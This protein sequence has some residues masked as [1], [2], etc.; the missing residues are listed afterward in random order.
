M[1]LGLPLVALLVL[2]IALFL[3][4]NRTPTAPPYAPPAPES[5]I[6][7]PALPAHFSGAAHAPVDEPPSPKSNV[8]RAYVKDDSFPK[9]TLEQVEPYLQANHRNAESLLGAFMATGDRAFVREAM[10]KFPNDPKVAYNALYFGNLSPEESRQWADT[11]K[12]VAPDNSMAGYASALDYMKSGQPDLALQDMTAAGKGTWTDYSAQFMQS[13]EEA[14]RAA[15][16]SDVDAKFAAGTQLLLPDLGQLKQLGVQIN[17]LAKTYQQAGNT[18]AAQNALQ[19]DVQLGQQLSAIDAQPLITTL[20]GYAVEKIALAS[21]DPNAPFG[22]TGQTV[23]DQ[24]NQIAQQR[25][26]IKSVTSQA[27]GLVAQMSDDDVFS[28]FQRRQASGEIAAMQWALAKY[29]P[30]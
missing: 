1:K 19:M 10:Q 24:I 29:S 22:N 25:Q 3:F 17:D 23:Q 12:R 27:D 15:G 11:F 16:Y 5:K 18:T 14:Y 8:F 7:L 6:T 21:M 28:Y 4:L 9:L 30:Q 13:S 20:V 26:F 2:V